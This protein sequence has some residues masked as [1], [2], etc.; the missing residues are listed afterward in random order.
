MVTLSSD[1]SASYSKDMLNYEGLDGL[2]T[3]I[4][5]EVHHGFTSTICS[6]GGVCNVPN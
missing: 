2:Y 1:F 3:V 4:L 6:F 5:V